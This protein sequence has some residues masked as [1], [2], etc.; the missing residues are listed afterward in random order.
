MKRE[1]EVH[2]H[3]PEEKA[4]LFSSLNG[5]S[6]EVEYRRLLVGLAGVLKPERALETGI[7]H[8]WALA[9]LAAEC[10]ELV[11]VDHSEAAVVAAGSLG[12]PNLRVYGGDARK[13]LRGWQGG[14]F[15]LVFL[16]TEL[17]SRASEL[18]VLLERGLLT[19]R[20]VVAIHDTSRVR[21]MG[22][23]RC[24]ESLQFWGAFEA[25]RKKWRLEVV[26]LPLSRGMLLVQRAR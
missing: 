26:E 11:V 12:V 20:A 8:P 15:D 17:G 1:S 4:E 24:L 23:G 21:V 2:P 19:P 7:L 10:R 6:T 13:W 22:G 18:E 5:G 3:V 14:P 25:L 16:D 9:G